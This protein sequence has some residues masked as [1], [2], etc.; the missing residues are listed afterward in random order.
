MSLPN[1]STIRAKMITNIRFGEVKKNS[2]SKK[3][4]TKTNLTQLLNSK[5]SLQKL[6]QLQIYFCHVVS[7]SSFI[8]LSSFISLPSLSSISFTSLLSHFFYFSLLFHISSS[9]T[10]AVCRFKTPLDRLMVLCPRTRDLLRNFAHMDR[11]FPCLPP[12]LCRRHPLTRAIWLVR[13]T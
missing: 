12:S 10:Q 13:W 7:L 5:K 3:M 9:L 6:R 4:L 8:T 1:N 11:S 2:V